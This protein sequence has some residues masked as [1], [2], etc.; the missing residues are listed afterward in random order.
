MN[1][2]L[3]CAG[4]GSRL[5]PLTNFYPK[6]LI[7]ISKVKTL[8]DY[9]IEKLIE[10]CF[11]NKVLINVHYKHRS[12]IDHINKNKYRNKI[13]IKYEKKILGTAGTLIN[14]L[15]FFENKNGL[16]IHSD[17]IC[18]ENLLTFIKFSKKYFNH[19]INLSIFAFK[20]NDYKNSG[21][22]HD[23]NYIIKKFF[24]K[25][26]KPHGIWANG[27]IFYINKNY[28]KKLKNKKFYDFSRDIIPRNINSALVFKSK[29]FFIDIGTIK[30][31]RCFKQ[32]Y[33]E[34]KIKINNI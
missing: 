19:K 2:I 24:E 21:I 12:I 29:N 6:P 10:E 32:M 8:L 1:A 13:L 30:K 16:V 9:W 28:Y 27:G 26:N 33:N 17:N 20:T 25:A 5:S 22:I 3:L 15:N 4:Y 23:K 34:K 31:L 18:N 11:V 14:N 7:K